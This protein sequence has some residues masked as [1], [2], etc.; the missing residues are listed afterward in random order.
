MHFK[1]EWINDPSTRDD[2]LRLDF[3]SWPKL[4]RDA[5]RGLCRAGKSVAALRYRGRPPAWIVKAG[6]RRRSATLFSCSTRPF[7]SS[8]PYSNTEKMLPTIYRDK[9]RRSVTLNRP[10][11]EGL[12]DSTQIV[13]LRL[14]KGAS[15]GLVLEFK[16]N[17]ARSG[18][19]QDRGEK[20][21]RPKVCE[22]LSVSLVTIKFR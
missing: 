14:G 4:C 17:A 1:R 16:D 18:S 15:L 11:L 7:R 12:A 21:S 10:P 20:P 8:A 13:D 9:Q 6:L 3:G 2:V 5:S 22:K 19:R